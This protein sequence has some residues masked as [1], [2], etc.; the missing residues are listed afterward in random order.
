[1]SSTKR[2]VESGKDCGSG[3]LNDNFRMDGFLIN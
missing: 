2:S 3:K 1:M